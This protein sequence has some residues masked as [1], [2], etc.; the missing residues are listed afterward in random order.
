MS[1]VDKELLDNRKVKILSVEQDGTTIHN[2][3]DTI[4]KIDIAKGRQELPAKGP[5]KDASD[6]VFEEIKVLHVYTTMAGLQELKITDMPKAKRFIR[7]W[8]EFAENG[9]K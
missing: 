5:I 2:V 6:L 9:Y 3:A 4:I 8:K 7:E 1:G